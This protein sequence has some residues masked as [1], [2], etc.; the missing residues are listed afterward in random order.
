MAT[1]TSPFHSLRLPAT[2]G[3]EDPTDDRHPGPTENQK[4]GR[5]ETRSRI[6]RP[7]PPRAFTYRLRPCP[8]TRAQAD[9][10]QDSDTA[11]H[12]RLED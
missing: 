12:R 2:A 7:L 10:Q 5:K 4:H 8:R 9:K 3:Q 6:H 1:P 11:E